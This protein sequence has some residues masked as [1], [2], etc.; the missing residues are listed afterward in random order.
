MALDYDL[1]IDQ[2]EDYDRVIPVTDTT[3]DEEPVDVTGW[4]ILGQIRERYESDTILHTLNITIAGTEL[5]L[6][7]PG[8]VSSAWTWR[9]ARY[10][11]KLT[12]P[13]LKRRRFMKG[14]VVV[15]P[16]VSRT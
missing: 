9:L 12:S 16:E 3:P 8:S 15:D 14:M 5:I 11:I 6:S 4:S 13:D 2:G 7:I 10:D 1:E